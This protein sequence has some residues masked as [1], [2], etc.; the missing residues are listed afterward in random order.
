MNT[1]CRGQIRVSIW[2]CQST[3]KY[4]GH[5]R[6][7]REPVGQPSGKYDIWHRAEAFWTM[8]IP[9]FKRTTWETDNTA[10]FG[11]QMGLQQKTRRT[12]IMRSKI[13][14]YT[15][16]VFAELKQKH[17]LTKSHETLEQAYTYLSCY[18]FQQLRL[19]SNPR[20]PR[21]VGS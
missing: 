17:I 13:T 14:S 21:V 6:V 19:N 7:Q 12:G 10:T 1:D 11:S 18:D 16:L 2:G 20:A 8:Q 5:I 15:I 9:C 3:V 4:Y